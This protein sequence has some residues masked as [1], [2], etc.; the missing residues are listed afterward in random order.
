MSHTPPQTAK[1]KRDK[2]SH[3]LSFKGRETGG[4]SQQRFIQS[5]LKLLISLRCCG[6]T[7]PTQTH[8]VA[9]LL[10]IQGLQELLHS[11]RNGTHVHKHTHTHTHTHTL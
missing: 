10:Q 2:T 5:F 8:V 1:K 4:E 3:V 11:L 9:A 7:H 6:S